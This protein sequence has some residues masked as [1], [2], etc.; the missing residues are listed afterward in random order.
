MKVK[1]A[2]ECR[3]TARV[4]TGQRVSL[5][6]IEEAATETRDGHTYWA[7]EHT[8]QVPL[9]SFLPPCWHKHCP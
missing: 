7:Y 4:T 6:T 9:H 1:L 8:S 2:V 3:S 5:N